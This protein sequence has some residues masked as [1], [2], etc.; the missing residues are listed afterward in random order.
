MT[1]LR[2][3]YS[4]F[5][6]AGA[7][8]LGI[9]VDSRFSLRQFGLSLGGLPF[10]LLADFFPHGK[11]SEMYG[12]LNPE[13]GVSGRSVFIID[14]S[15]VVQYANTAYRPTETDALLEAVKGVPG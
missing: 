12:I 11:V 7:Q 8:V 5:E 6:E 10:P 14:T 15:G 9:S 3:R 2:T 4:E 1:S 13:S